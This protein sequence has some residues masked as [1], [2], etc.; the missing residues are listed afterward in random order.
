MSGAGAL[1]MLCAMAEAGMAL[2]TSLPKPVLVIG[3]AAF[4]LALA[5]PTSRRKIL[6]LGAGGFAGGGAVVGNAVLPMLKAHVR[7]GEAAQAS[8]EQA[9]ATLAASK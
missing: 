3:A 9:Q 7:A 5:H 2:V 8:R 4:A 1:F 6:E